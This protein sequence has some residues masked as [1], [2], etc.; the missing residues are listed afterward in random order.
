MIRRWAVEGA[1]IALKSYLDITA[2]LKAKRLVTIMD[3]YQHD[4]SRLGTSLGSDLHA[5][6]PNRKFIPQRTTEFIR[7]LKEYFSLETKLS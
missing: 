1:G 7:A 5:I 4:F 3:N 6:Y 2:D